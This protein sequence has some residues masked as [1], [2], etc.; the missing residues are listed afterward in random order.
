[1]WES[2]CEWKLEIIASVVAR[3]EAKAPRHLLGDLY[4]SNE[5]TLYVF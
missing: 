4:R 3:M 2:M 1:M 5:K